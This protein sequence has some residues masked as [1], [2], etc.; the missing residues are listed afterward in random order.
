MQRH[1]LQFHNERPDEGEAWLL[2]AR[3]DLVG[4][5]REKTDALIRAWQAEEGI[6]GEPTYHSAYTDSSRPRAKDEWDFVYL[7]GRPTR[8]QMEGIGDRIARAHFAFLVTERVNLD[9]GERVTDPRTKR[10]DHLMREL[11]ADLE[12]A[13]PK[14][15]LN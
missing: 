4:T 5:N 7:P 6:E 2:K 14:R 13:R 8:V 12:A 15:E 11:V 1:P 3:S 10:L 9:T